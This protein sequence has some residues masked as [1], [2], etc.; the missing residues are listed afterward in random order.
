RGAKEESLN[1]AQAR[2]VAHF[3]PVSG[4]RRNA[5]TQSRQTRVHAETRKETSE[6][7]LD[8]RSD[9]VYRVARSGDGFRKTRSRDARVDVRHGRARRGIDDAQS[10]GRRF[11]QSTRARDGKTQE[12]A[13]RALRRT[14]GRRDSRLSRRARQVSLK[15]SGYKT[16]RRSA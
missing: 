12:A 4:A 3:L 13:D 9:Q 16:R 7:S 11:R 6:A 1:R 5:G 2:R 14:R 8:R 10:G 15:R